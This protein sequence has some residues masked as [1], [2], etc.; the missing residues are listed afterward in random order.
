MNP[1]PIV[2]TDDR[3]QRVKQAF[4]VYWLS[5]FCSGTILLGEQ[6]LSWALDATLLETKAYA[7]A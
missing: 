4:K 5:P 3:I 7:D 6:L 2:L 1:H